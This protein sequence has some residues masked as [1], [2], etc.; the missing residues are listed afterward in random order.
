[1]TAYIPRTNSTN[2]HSQEVIDNNFI[3][4]SSYLGINTYG[5]GAPADTM[6]YFKSVFENNN[7]YRVNLVE[8]N[9]HI[10]ADDKL[11][12]FSDTTLDSV[13]DAKAIYKKRNLRPQDASYE[14]LTRYNLAYNFAVDGNYPYRDTKHLDELSIMSLENAIIYL[15]T[16]G[17][18]TWKTHFLYIIS[19]KSTKNNQKAVDILYDTAVTSNILPRVLVKTTDSKTANY[20]DGKYPN[21]KRTATTSEIWQFYTNFTLGINMSKKAPRYSALL[22]P[23]NAFVVK[24]DKKS[25]VDYAH[26]HGI[27]VMYHTI[28]NAKVIKHLNEIGAD[29]ILTNNPYDA[30][31]AINNII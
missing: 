19:I 21:L 31:L 5:N 23:K 25:I 9:I 12:V 26:K 2:Y 3:N 30:F 10:T 15:E 7:S 6:T 17:K 8:L 18:D 13:S 24:L 27:A 20:I 14:Q 28:D 1:M 22:I 29:A 11:V 16:R 4:S